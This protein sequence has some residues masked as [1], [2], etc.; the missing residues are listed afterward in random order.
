MEEKFLH[1]F[2]R[3][4]GF[5][6]IQTKQQMKEIIQLVLSEETKKQYVSRSDETIIAEFSKE[7]ADS[8]G[9]SVCGIYSEEEEFEFEYSFPYFTG[10]CISSNE[11]IAIERHAEKESY[12]GICEDLK[13]GVSLIFYLQ[14]RMDYILELERGN[15]PV[16]NTSVNLSGLSLQGSIMLPIKKNEKE[17][18]KTQKAS[19]NRSH[20]LAAAR[21]GDEEAI[22]SLTMEDIDT[23]STIS[24]KILK[25]DVFSLVDTY[26]MP[27]GIECD[28][29]SILGEI[30][31]YRLAENQLTHEQIYIIT[32]NCN[33][34]I[35][36]VC[37]NQKD[38]IGE[39]L[40][41]RRFKGTI[42]MQG[43]VNFTV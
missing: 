37:I 25:E 6:E 40:P 7:F 26:F 13:V 41:K 34:L 15:L 38:L 23:Y 24:R 1:R 10:N 17:N 11:D 20:L 36:D 19:I 22:E 2:L 9:I 21:Q 14:N 31:E 35:L 16:Q 3:A 32:L 18:N 29:Y 39:P 4:I 5:S 12:A 28:Q 43:H 30:V 27:Y 8:M 33:D 42:W